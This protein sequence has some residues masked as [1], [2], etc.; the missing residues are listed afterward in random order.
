M[1]TVSTATRR[2]GSNQV[3][4]TSAEWR[5]AALMPWLFPLPSWRISRSGNGAIKQ[6]GSAESGWGCGT[7]V[8]GQDGLGDYYRLQSVHG[9][10]PRTDVGRSLAM[11]Q[12]SQG[13]SPLWVP[14]R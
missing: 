9:K 4:T 11:P 10:H 3:A 8:K 7:A 1:R 5:W 13:L 14:S 12:I 2:M 6:Q